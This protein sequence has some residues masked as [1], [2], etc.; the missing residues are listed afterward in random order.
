MVIKSEEQKPITSLSPFIIE[1]Q[2]EA[3]IG[4]PNTVKKLKNHTLLVET[5]RKSQNENLL[6]VTKFYNLQ[7]TVTEHKTLNTSKGILRDR[8]LKGEKEADICYYL[9]SQG[10]VAV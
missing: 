9:K 7:V 1:K 10:V 5:T 8:T 2:I 6:K 4:T 3:L